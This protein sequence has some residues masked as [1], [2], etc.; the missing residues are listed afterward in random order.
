E[1]KLEGIIRAIKK[2]K[3]SNEEIAEIFDVSVEYV[4][5]IK[6]KIKS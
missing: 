4:L 6:M 5:E 2:A 1:E 3:F